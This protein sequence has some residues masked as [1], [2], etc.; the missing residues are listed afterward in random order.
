MRSLI[1]F[2]GL[3]F[4]SGCGG[5]QTEPPGKQA[6]APAVDGTEAAKPA[7][8][9]GGNEPAG[10]DVLEPDCFVILDG[11]PDYGEPPLRVHFE[12]DVDCTSAPVTY[13]WDFGDGTKGGNEA[14]PVHTYEKTGE[15]L[16]IVRVSAPD[17]G[18]S[19]DELDIEVEAFEAE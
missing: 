15:Y 13:S 12:T 10:A 7:P 16:A 3:V 9:M 6:P 5:C 2:V 1:L 17:G 18:A 14:N 11:E 8:A 4:V 19:D